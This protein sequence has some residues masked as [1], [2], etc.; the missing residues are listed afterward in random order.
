MLLGSW[1]S[2]EWLCEPPSESVQAPTIYLLLAIPAFFF[3]FGPTAGLDFSPRVS[4]EPAGVLRP[5]QAV[6]DRDEP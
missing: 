1:S 3:L 2:L 6:G 4:K 5:N